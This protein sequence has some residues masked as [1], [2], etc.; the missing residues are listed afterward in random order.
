MW[1]NVDRGQTLDR[2][3]CFALILFILH[4]I[5]LVLRKIVKIVATRYHILKLKC[6]KFNVK[7]DTGNA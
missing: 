6:T 4:E 2:G 3:Q 5:W 1:T 7:G